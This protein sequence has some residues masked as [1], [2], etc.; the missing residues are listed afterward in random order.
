M[1][2]HYQSILRGLV[3]AEGRSPNVCRKN[4]EQMYLGRRRETKVWDFFGMGRVICCLV[5][6]GAGLSMNMEV[7]GKMQTDVTLR[8]SNRGVFYL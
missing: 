5:C 8:V 3:E 4:R 1:N 6:S 7:E 2:A